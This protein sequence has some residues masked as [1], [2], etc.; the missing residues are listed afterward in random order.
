MPLFPNCEIYIYIYKKN[1]RTKKNSRSKYIWSAEANDL[2]KLT[3]RPVDLGIFKEFCKTINV[4]LYIAANIEHQELNLLLLYNSILSKLH[5]NRT[6]LAFFM[7]LVL[8]WK[9]AEV[10]LHYNTVA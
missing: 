8:S 5:W 1:G 9:I 7:S 3:K 4:E 2:L 6:A 10:D